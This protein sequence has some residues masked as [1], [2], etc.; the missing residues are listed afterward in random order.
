[1]YFK[2][3][4]KVQCKST[5]YYLLS[6]PH[7]CLTRWW[8]SPLTGASREPCQSLVIFFFAL[9]MYLTRYSQCSI[10]FCTITLNKNKPNECTCEKRSSQL[11]VY[12][13]NQTQ[14][15]N[16]CPMTEI[17]FI[18]PQHWRQSLL[19]SHSPS[20]C[21]HFYLLTVHSPYFF[22]KIIRIKRLPICTSIVVSYCVM[23]G[24]GSGFKTFWGGRWEK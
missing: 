14:R 1:M 12:K 11:S 20:M 8:I 3:T 9:H 15:H 5:Y 10:I 7:C 6:S 24:Q 23:R 22:R 19:V 17:K 2:C 13:L 21:T 4:W 18:Q 16:Y